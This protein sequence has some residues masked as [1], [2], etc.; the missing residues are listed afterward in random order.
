MIRTLASLRAGDN[1][2]RKASVTPDP[3]RHG[4]AR[5]GVA[6]HRFGD[7]KAATRGAAS[8]V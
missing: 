1:G 5:H 8:P 4:T 6:R 7:V 3:A 2:A